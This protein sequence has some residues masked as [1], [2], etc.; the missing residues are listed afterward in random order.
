MATGNPFS[1]MDP[2]QLPMTL[3]G[4]PCRCS[5]W[6]WVI[7]E[8]SRLSVCNQLIDYLSPLTRPGREVALAKPKASGQPSGEPLGSGA[9]ETPSADPCC[10]AHVP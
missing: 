2:C 1:A 3:E 4:H 7:T 6:G 8:G 5:Q 9:R 10:Q